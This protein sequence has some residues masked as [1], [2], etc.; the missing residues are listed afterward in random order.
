MKGGGKRHFTLEIL[1]QKSMVML[2]CGIQVISFLKDY[3]QAQAVAGPNK[4]ERSQGQGDDRLQELGYLG[5]ERQKS[6]Q[7]WVLTR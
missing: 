7:V 6:L 4:L 1:H 2:Y 3:R 5:L